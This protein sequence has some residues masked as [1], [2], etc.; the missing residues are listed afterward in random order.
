VIPPVRAHDRAP[1]VGDADDPPM[2]VEMA[3]RVAEDEPDPITRLERL[4]CPI[5]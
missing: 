2:A 4:R 3:A 5:R 1:R